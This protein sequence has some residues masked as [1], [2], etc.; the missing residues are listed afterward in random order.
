MISNKPFDN[1][2]TGILHKVKDEE[3]SIFVPDGQYPKTQRQMNLYQYH[4]FIESI[5]RGKSYKNALEMGC[6]R[7]TISL[8]LRTRNHLDVTLTDIEASA[9]ELAKKNFKQ[10]DE[11]GT[12]IVADSQKIPLP[13]NSFD[14]VVSIGLLEH[15]DD[16]SSILK[17]KYRLLRPG[18]VVV[19]LNIPKK[20]SVQLLNTWYRK[21]LNIIGTKHELKK[22]YF[23]NT[24]MPDAY[25]KKAKDAGFSDI[26]IIH[27]NPFP[28]FTPLSMSVERVLIYLYRAII[29]V[30]GIFMKYPYKTNYRA[31]QAHFLVAYKK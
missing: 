19:S 18:G 15:F 1:K 5:I 20:M 4:K 13:D 30:R 28:I 10:M 23:R 6:G 2:W 9:I 12:F 27:V 17:E 31:S 14:I 25:E 7:G 29:L 11:R 3:F 8:Y 26:S 16:Y 22:D 24:D 21:L